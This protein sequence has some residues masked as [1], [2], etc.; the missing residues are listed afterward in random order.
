MTCEQLSMELSTLF[1]RI[2]AED[3]GTFQ[4]ESHVVK[5]QSDWNITTVSEIGAAV[6]SINRMVDLLVV[7]SARVER[8]ISWCKVLAVVS[9]SV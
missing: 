7:L 2:A 9:M 1:P 6:V 3:V 8:Y 5:S 4:L